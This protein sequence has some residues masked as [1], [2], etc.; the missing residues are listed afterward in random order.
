M[1]R[2]GEVSGV[3]PAPGQAASPEELPG[4]ERKR[5]PIRDQGPQRIATELPESVRVGHALQI[6][7]EVPGTGIGEAARLLSVSVAAIEA[8][9]MAQRAE[10]VAAGGRVH[11]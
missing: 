6:L 11:R 9:L 7:R 2:F 5:L 1:K 4:S 10:V 8:A 3:S